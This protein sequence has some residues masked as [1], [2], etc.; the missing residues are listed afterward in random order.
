M[1]GRR[2]ELR[3]ALLASRGFATT[4]PKPQD[5]SGFFVTRCLFSIFHALKKN[6][7]QNW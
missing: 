2:V 6:A 5:I 7:N 4:N 1:R 3:K